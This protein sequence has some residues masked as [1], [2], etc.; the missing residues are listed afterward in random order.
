MTDEQTP[1]KQEEQEQQVDQ[2]P[3]TFTDAAGSVWKPRL[4][5]DVL[6]KM[7]DRT[8]LRL[9]H[10][11]QAKSGNMPI[12]IADLFECIWYTI[13]EEAKDMSVTREEFMH[14]RLSVAE[15]PRCMLAITK[16]FLSSFPSSKEMSSSPLAQKLQEIVEVVQNDTG[17]NPTS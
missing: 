12:M 17:T 7:C 6:I 3:P 9:D 8:G 11:F 1:E 16:A 5:A 10:L 13:E 15:L 4:T 14:K 2:G